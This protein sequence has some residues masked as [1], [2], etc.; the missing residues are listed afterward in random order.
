MSLPR[1]TFDDIVADIAQRGR[2]LLL[3]TLAALVIIVVVV[4]VGRAFRP[5]VRRYLRRAGRPSRMRVF[6]A[7]YQFCVL[8]AAVLL[9]LTL[10]FP[11]VRVSDVLASLGIVSVA[12]GFAFKDVLQN[13]LAGVLLLM[14]DPFQS[15]DQIRV[16][17][18]EGTVE[19]VTVRETLIR[20]YDGQLVLI[21]NAQVYTSPLEVR[22]HYPFTRLAFRLTVPADTDVGKL[23]RCVVE[24]LSDLTPDGA[25]APDTVVTSVRTGALEV[26][27]RLWSR[28]PRAETTSSLDAGITATLSALFAAGIPLDEPA[29]VV[30]TPTTT[31]DPV[32]DVTDPRAA[33][34]TTSTS[35]RAEEGD[36]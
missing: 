3:Q 4:L 32:V 17:G 33:A 2:E 26:E 31:N 28:A 7:L 18:T 21:P 23:Q 9:A 13:L 29:I 25:P 22:T 34:A 12:V 36:Q 5:L 30:K 19:G 24:T 35:R 6:T 8:V 1:A 10:A 14:R 11:S 16:S 20:T 15:G 27:I